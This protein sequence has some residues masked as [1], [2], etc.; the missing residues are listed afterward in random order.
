VHA[1]VDLS[2]GENENKMVQIALVRVDSFEM[3]VLFTTLYKA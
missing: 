1:V 2:L 3:R